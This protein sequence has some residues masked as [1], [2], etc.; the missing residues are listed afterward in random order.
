MT[1]PD[2]LYVTDAELIRRLGV[3]EKIARQAIMMLDKDPKSSG[4]P[5]KSAFWG[6]RRYWPAVMKW[7]DKSNGLF[8]QAERRAS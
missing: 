4:F 8:P 1:T 5:Q 2:P 7:L 3:P 6:G